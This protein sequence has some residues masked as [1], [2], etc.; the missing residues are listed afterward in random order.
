[1]CYAILEVKIKNDSNRDPLKRIDSKEDLAKALVQYERM[2]T[3][4]KV[5]VFL[6]HHA[7]KLTE[8]WVDELY[9]EP[10]VEQ[11]SPIS[12]QLQAGTR[13]PA[14][15]ESLAQQQTA[16]FFAGHPYQGG[17]LKP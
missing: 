8:A 15:L 5:T 1:M 10:V 4:E 17:E 12:A 6:N 9:H 16:A 3:V 13:S 14:E 2:G 11:Q 7:H